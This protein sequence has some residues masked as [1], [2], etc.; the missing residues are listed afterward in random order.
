MQLFHRGTKQAAKPC[1]TKSGSV[2]Y[3][4][5]EVEHAQA[6]KSMGSRRTVHMLPHHANVAT[7][8]WMSMKDAT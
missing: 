2:A 8:T 5:K 1:L 3:A 6:Q 7:Y 4:A